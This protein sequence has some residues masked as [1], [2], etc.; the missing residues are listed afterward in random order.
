VVIDA[1]ISLDMND[2]RFIVMD[3]DPDDGV[4]L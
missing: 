2:A 1:V 4:S 3:E